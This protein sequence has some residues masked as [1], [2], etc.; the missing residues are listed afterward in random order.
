MRDR[1]L[2]SIF[3]N[4]NID[5]NPL[6]PVEPTLTAN[7]ERVNTMLHRFGLTDGFL[8]VVEPNLKFI[9]DKMKLSERQALLLSAF[10][11]LSDADNI[12][13][14]MLSRFMKCSNIKVMGMSN[15]MNELYHRGFLKNGN[16]HSGLRIAKGYRVPKDVKEAVSS[17]MAFEPKSDFNLDI[18]EVF[19]RIS[20]C[21]E[22]NDEEDEIVEQVNHL[23]E[24]N[25]HLSFSN[26][27]L[28]NIVA[29][30]NTD[31]QFIFYIICSKL[32]NEGCTSVPEFEFFSNLNQ[33]HVKPLRDH[34]MKENTMLQKNG[35][36]EVTAEN[37]LFGHRYTLTQNAKEQLLSELNLQ[38][39]NKKKDLL[40]SDS[41][42]ENQLFYN[43]TEA[44]KIAQLTSLLQNDNFKAVQ[45]R[46]DQMNLRKGFACLF[47]GAPGTG[48][49][50]TVK[51]LARLTGR[52]VMLIDVSQIKNKFVGESEKNIKAA[53]SRYREY[54][55]TCEV[56]P[57]LL[58]NEADAV[59]GVRM[60][61]AQDAVDKM[62]N[63]IQNII[64]Q[65][66]ENLEGI[67]IAT[68]NLTKNLDKAFERRFI[69][70]IEF[71]NPD[72]ETQKK[73][74]LSKLP[75]MHEDLA[76]KLAGQFEL[77]G[78]QIENIVR[79]SAINYVLNGTN[80]TDDQY[81]T[82]CQ[83]ELLDSKTKHQLH[84]VGFLA[85]KYNGNE[86]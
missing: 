36:I 77:S 59:L 84:P 69:F 41:F 11:E 25:R 29:N 67:M 33:S 22:E 53:F 37:S 45:S 55:K 23:L 85:S 26:E 51:Q 61:G 27:V 82:Y 5:V 42:K 62:E 10:I 58:F 8:T 28:N 43:E 47:Y 17:N 44:G 73:I 9:A 83:D 50:E 81:M 70:K 71:H 1:D 78:G 52:D 68:T 34:L 66:M 46:M 12:T 72:K 74:W 48:K 86:D 4:N 63:S 7:M 13:N 65:E 32:V 38:T 40:K 76:D 54:V 20:E 21:F 60:E 79:K 49:T 57:I 19:L 24:H 31:E 18:Y 15:D 16:S 56:A 2:D 3:D 80:L 6:E 75:D 30:C 35:I 64:L 39:A 14:A